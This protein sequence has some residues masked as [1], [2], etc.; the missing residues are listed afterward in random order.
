M[1]NSENERMD[2]CPAAGHE[3]NLCCGNDQVPKYPI[4][5]EIPMPND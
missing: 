4:P 2:S 1:S 5:K 3:V